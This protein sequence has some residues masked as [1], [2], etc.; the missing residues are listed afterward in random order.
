[1]AEDIR[2]EMSTDFGKIPVDIETDFKKV[3]TS[4]LFDSIT[5]QMSDMSK[6]AK[7]FKRDFATDPQYSVY[8]S[9]DY[10]MLA[11]ELANVLRSA[12][13]SPQVSVEM[14]D[15]DVYLDSER[16]GRKVAPIVSRVQARGVKTK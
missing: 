15:G 3:D 10:G 14:N 9:I 1:M 2:D 4:N 6:Y 8:S 12:P 16:V 11:K 13:I 5:M 7:E